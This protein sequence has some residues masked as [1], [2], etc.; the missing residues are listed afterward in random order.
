VTD[1]SPEFEV[2]RLARRLSADANGQPPA[3]L[4]RP[5]W[6]IPRPKLQGS[7]GLLFAA[8][9]LGRIA[10]GDGDVFAA[11]SAAV[12]VAFFATSTY[13]WHRTRK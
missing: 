13:S 4:K 3:G 6:Y 5:W 10:T 12:G 9:N 11:V 7:L 2:Q 8:S 1:R